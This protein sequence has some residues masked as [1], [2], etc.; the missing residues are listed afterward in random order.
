MLRK[1]AVLFSGCSMGGWIDFQSARDHSGIRILWM[2]FR[3]PGT[4]RKRELR[5]QGAFRSF[6]RRFPLS[7]QRTDLALPSRNC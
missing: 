5:I 7:L 1:T 6:E 2:A 3:P 4:C